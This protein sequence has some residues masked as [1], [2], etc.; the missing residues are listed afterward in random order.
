MHFLLLTQYFPPEVGAPQ[1]R[2]LALARQLREHGHQVTVV[3]AMPNYPAGVVQPAYRR[4]WLVREEVEGIPVIR[5][6]IYA[7]SGSNVTRRMAGYLSF[8]A[9]SLLGC[10]MAR[11]PD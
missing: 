3:T 6:W 2:L 9:S 10:L 5:T 7:A 8:C 11:R 4:R 1:V